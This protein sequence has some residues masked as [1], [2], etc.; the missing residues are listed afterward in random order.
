MET[1]LLL[2]EDQNIQSFGK[3]NRF[4]FPSNLHYLENIGITLKY[5]LKRNRIATAM[6]SH[7]NSFPSLRLKI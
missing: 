6:F 3:Q 7:I 2:A 5:R 4:A 1:I